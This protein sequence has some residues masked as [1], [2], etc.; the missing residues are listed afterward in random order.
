[1]TSRCKLIRS[2]NYLTNKKVFLCERKKHTA[3]CVASPYLYWRGYLPWW[4]RVTYLGCWGGGV[5][6]LVAGGVPT[7]VARGYYLGWGGTYLDQG[8]LPWLGGTYLGQRVTYLDQEVPTLVG[9]PTLAG[10][11]Y[12]GQ[13][14][15]LPWLRGYLPWLG[16]PTLAR[17][18]P[19][20]AEGVP[21]LAGGT[22][23]GQRGTYL[24]QGYP[25][26]PGRVSNL[27][28]IGYPPRCGQSP[29]KT[30][31]SRCTTYVGSN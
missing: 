21:T 7:L 2:P 15:Y 31:P 3:H 16:V 5:P 29:V 23:L 9:V 30:V 25:P 27:A 18:V 8:Y 19:T 12:L 28:G 14:R 24:S 4:L 17:E 13:G 26:W 1:M 22:Y 11:T 20:L 6:T 10:G